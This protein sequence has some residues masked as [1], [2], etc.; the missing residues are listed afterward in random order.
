MTYPMPGRQR[1]R[2]LLN[3][4]FRFGAQR[5]RPVLVSGRAKVSRVLLAHRIDLEIKLTGNGISRTS[6]RT[7]NGFRFWDWNRSFLNW[8]R[9]WF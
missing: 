3:L 8:D 5:S 7:R 2:N 1:G 6:V 9:F 4:R